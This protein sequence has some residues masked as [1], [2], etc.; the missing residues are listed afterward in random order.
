[1]GVWVCVGVWVGVCAGE[2][3]CLLRILRANNC[4]V[5]DAMTQVTTRDLK[6]WWV[7]CRRA[8][9]RSRGR[10]GRP[11]R[12]QM[13]GILEY[14][15]KYNVDNLN[16]LDALTHK[17]KPY[18]VG[19]MCGVATNG[20]IKGCTVQVCLPPAPPRQHLQLLGASRAPVACLPAVYPGARRQ[21]RVA[22]HTPQLTA[23]CCAKHS[24]TALAIRG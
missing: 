16:P 8:P 5:E 12:N 18:W 17:C 1:M 23:R 22:T 4:I 9:G 3:R 2:G 11:C 13:H 7:A 21:S 15:A 19:E 6:Y 24:V 14:R 20:H 10:V